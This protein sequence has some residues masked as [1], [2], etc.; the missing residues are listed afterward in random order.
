MVYNIK[1][2]DD[3]SYFKYD[4]VDSPTVAIIIEGEKLL[5][6]KNSDTAVHLEPYSIKS[7]TDTHKPV[8]IKTVYIYIYILY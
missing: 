4:L 8:I 5:Y 2:V 6:F 1:S 3:G 7:D